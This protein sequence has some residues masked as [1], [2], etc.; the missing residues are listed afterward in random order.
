[1]GQPEMQPDQSDL[2]GLAKHLRDLQELVTLML[3]G[4]SRAKPWQRQLA[5]HLRDVDQKLQVM[6][7]TV[8]ME[9][10]GAELLSAADAVA[11]AC[12]LT[13]AALAGSRVDPTT[14]KAVHLMVDLSSRIHAAL[15]E[16]QR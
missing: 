7:M 1:M 12:R 2:A 4:L 14:R 16:L 11:G 8:A 9:K 15:G 10:D 5:D 3:A 6:R 13:A